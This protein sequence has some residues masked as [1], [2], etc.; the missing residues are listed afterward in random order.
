MSVYVRFK[1]KGGFDMITNFEVYK[2]ILKVFTDSKEYPCFYLS[3]DA[4]ELLG[5]YRWGSHR[6]GYGYI[7]A[8]K[9]RQLH[10]LQDELYRFYNGEYSK[11]Y[12]YFMNGVLIDCTDNN[13]EEVPVQDTYTGVPRGYEIYRHMGIKKAYRPYIMVD[14]VEFAP[15]DKTYS[16]DEACIMQHKLETE[17][18]KENFG[19]GILFNFFKY[20]KGSEDILD[21][22]YTGRISAEEAVYKH[23]MRYAD[24][25]WYYLRFGLQGYFKDNKI[26][27][28]DYYLDDEGHMVHP[29]THRHLCP[30]HDYA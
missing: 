12:L 3:S 26:P 20:R 1:M 17:W 6:K 16:E 4:E 21:E 27:E 23:I 28:P 18:L 11:G 15:Y 19:V 22:E 8:I 29:D 24:N 9:D 25:A 7:T 30:I 14:G 13:L 2:D 5:Q 10:Y